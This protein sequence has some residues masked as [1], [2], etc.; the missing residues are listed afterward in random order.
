M[1]SLCIDIKQL[2]QSAL[3]HLHGQTLPP[4]I[5]EHLEQCRFCREQFASLLGQYRIAEQQFTAFPETAI[6]A[7][8]VVGNKPRS[9]YVLVASFLPA[10][11]VPVRSG[12]VINT[13]AADSANATRNIHYQNMGT[14]STS[15]GNLLVRILLDSRGGDTWLH[16]IAEDA[17]K[18]R[19]VPIHIDPL[20]YDTV[21]DNSGRVNLGNIRLPELETLKVSVHTPRAVFDLSA[22][23]KSWRELVGKGEILVKNQTN[24]QVYIEF[25]PE[26]SGYR[27]SVRL[28]TTQVSADLQKIQ[29]VASKEYGAGSLHPVQQGIAIFH[30]VAEDA[31]LQVKVFG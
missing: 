19:N 31:S 23:K 12:H 1:I 4:A 22:L 21:S 9:D 6:Q 7:L 28:D 11:R 14:L 18:I 24:D 25:Q 15:D 16:L 30:N 10:T 29:V 27:L 5:E 2:E 20:G 3:H 26:G 8:T 13:R 17:D